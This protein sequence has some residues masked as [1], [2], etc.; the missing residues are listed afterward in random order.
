MKK[1]TGLCNL[2]VHRSINFSTT[3][4]R[5]VDRMG[6]LFHRL[7]S[8]LIWY[9]VIISWKSGISFVMY[10]GN[11]DVDLINGGSPWIMSVSI[12]IAK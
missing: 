11:C 9:M 5:P 6:K 3:N 1:E 4:G 7:K 10:L 8:D 2:M 12:T